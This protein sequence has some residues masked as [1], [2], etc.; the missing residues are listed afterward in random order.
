[1]LAWFNRP[2][3]PRHR[4]AATPF[5]PLLSML[6]RSSR[7]VARQPSEAMPGSVRL[8]G[9]PRLVLRNPN[10]PRCNRSRRSRA[11]CRL[12]GRPGRSRRAAGDARKHQH[13]EVTVQRDQLHG[14][15]HPGSAGG[16]GRGCLILHPSVR[17][18]HPT[19][20]P[21][22]YSTFAASRSTKATTASSPSRASTA[23]RRATASSRITSSASRCSRDPLPRSGHRTHGGVGG[24]INVV[25]K[26]AGEDLTRLTASYGSTSRFG[27]RWD[28]ARRYGESKE[29]AGR[30]RQPARR[31]HAHRPPVRDDGR[32]GA[33][34]RLSG[35]TVQ[36]LA[37]L[38]RPDRSI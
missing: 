17:S 18:T 8:R 23:S 25:P 13:D 6:R 2:L 4:R 12:R 15:V 10:P 3:D 32:R 30:E 14:Q 34:S 5:H 37:L 1:M 16:N 21:S 26:R 22:I 33:G 28:V 19:G 31:R 24:V 9:G 27:G 29:W 20:G 7:S 11:S 36:V 35:R 38:H